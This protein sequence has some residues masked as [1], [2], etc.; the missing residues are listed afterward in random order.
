MQETGSNAIFLTHA[1]YFFEYLHGILFR[2]QPCII[3]SLVC[4]EQTGHFESTVRIPTML[5]KSFEPLEVRTLLRSP[6]V[7]FSEV[8]YPSKGGSGP[9]N[10]IEM[11]I[12]GRLYFPV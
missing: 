9:S 7:T 12:Q 6:L 10:Q 8:V 1:P 5:L 11:F 4:A 2:N 3:I